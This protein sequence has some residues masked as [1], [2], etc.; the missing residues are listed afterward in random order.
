MGQES[1]AEV[2]LPMV[3]NQHALPRTEARLHA[4]TPSSA[5]ERAVLARPKGLQG[6]EG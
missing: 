1:I 6:S 4:L 5:V 2:L 3:S